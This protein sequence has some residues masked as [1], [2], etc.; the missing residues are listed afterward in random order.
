MHII[1]GLIIVT[2]GIFLGPAA[3]IFKKWDDDEDY[4]DSVSK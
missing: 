1:M 4:Y 3:K 2:L